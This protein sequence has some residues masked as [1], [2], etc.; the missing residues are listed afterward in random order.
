M[1][2]RGLFVCIHN[3]VPSQKAEVL[4]NQICGEEFEAHIASL[5][6]RGWMAFNDAEAMLK[7]SGLHIT[8]GGVGMAARK[9]PSQPGCFRLVAVQLRG[10]VKS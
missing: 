7:A 6:P 10:I 8:F 4:L 5:E 3:S 9:G 2:R 1:K